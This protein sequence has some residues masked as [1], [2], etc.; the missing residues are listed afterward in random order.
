MCHSE[1][2]LFCCPGAGYG[3]RTNPRPP[4]SGA[5]PG[6]RHP[7]SATHG[8]WEEGRGWEGKEDRVRDRERE[9]VTTHNQTG[10]VSKCR[11]RAYMKRTGIQ[12][13][14]GHSQSHSKQKHTQCDCKHQMFVTNHITKIYEVTQGSRQ[15]TQLRE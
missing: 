7:E 5:P 2:R 14:K 9:I 6:E 12:C 8:L 10:R 13:H 11:K 1:S 4:G 3:I 15:N